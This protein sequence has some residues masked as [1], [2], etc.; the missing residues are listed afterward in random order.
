MRLRESDASFTS[1]LSVVGRG[2]SGGDARR[3]EDALRMDGEAPA[4]SP[5]PN[6]NANPNHNASPNPKP[7][8]NPILTLNLSLEA[9]PLATSEPKPNTKPKPQPSPKSSPKSEPKP[10]AEEKVFVRRPI[11]KNRGSGA[12]E[13]NMESIA[14]RKRKASSVARL[15]NGPL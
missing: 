4:A 3:A 7:N 13:D 12:S 14:K 1:N 15:F 8:P 6:P 9:D 11:K 2:V 10:N 5:N